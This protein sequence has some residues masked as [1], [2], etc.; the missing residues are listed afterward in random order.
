MSN[1]S[2]LDPW[3]K[4]WQVKKAKEWSEKLKKLNSMGYYE[5]PWG[6]LR[7]EGW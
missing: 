1:E 5:G 3:T 4:A 2:V 6:I 7:E